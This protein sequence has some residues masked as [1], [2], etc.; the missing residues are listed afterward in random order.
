MRHAHF[1][2]WVA[3]VFKILLV[4]DGDTFPVVAMRIGRVSDRFAISI[5]PQTNARA[6]FV[7]GAYKEKTQVVIICCRPTIDILGK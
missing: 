2:V 3:P 1:L 5:S 7:Y 6:Q 4:A